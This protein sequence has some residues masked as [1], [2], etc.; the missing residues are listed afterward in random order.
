MV[1]FKTQL[2]A[3][4]RSLAISGGS[5]T[6]GVETFDYSTTQSFMLGATGERRTKQHR[7]FQHNNFNRSRGAQSYN[8]NKGG[9]RNNILC[10]FWLIDVLSC[11]I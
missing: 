9:G 2:E 10:V 1:L 3:R 5:S 6:Q 11:W 7:N 8:F 4:E